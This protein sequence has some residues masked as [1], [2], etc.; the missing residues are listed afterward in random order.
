MIVSAGLRPLFCTA[1]M[2]A[3][4]PGLMCPSPLRSRRTFADRDVTISYR[5]F[6][7]RPISLRA[8]LISSRRSPA[9]VSGE[10]L[11]RTTVL[12]DLINVDDGVLR[13]RN[14]LEVGQTIR[15]ERQIGRAHV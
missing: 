9:E 11:P 15:A 1:I 8:K 12:T 7:S 5:E 13:K 10:S 6:V 2:S 3:K 14:W 4:E